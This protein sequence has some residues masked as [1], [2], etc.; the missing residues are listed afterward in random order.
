MNQTPA[1]DATDAHRN[2]PST[3]KPE[4]GGLAPPV[5]EIRAAAA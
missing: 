1:H 5:F 4:A 3:T 2:D